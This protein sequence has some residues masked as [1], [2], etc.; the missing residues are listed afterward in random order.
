MNN[1]GIIKPAEKGDD[2]VRWC[3]SCIRVHGYLYICNSYPAE[4]KAQI[5]EDQKKF[6]ACLND[7]AWI[8]KQ[9]EGGVPD[10]VIRN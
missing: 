4:L 1:S 7:P 9:K 5:A 2:G 8:L 10:K 3:P 6:E